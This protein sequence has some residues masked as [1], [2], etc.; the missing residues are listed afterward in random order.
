M[1]TVGATIDVLKAQYAAERKIIESGPSLREVGEKVRWVG[2]E[3]GAT[4]GAFR[5]MFTDIARWQKKVSTDGFVIQ[6]ESPLEELHFDTWADTLD[7]LTDNDNEHA[8][9]YYGVIQELA[10][11]EDDDEESDD[12]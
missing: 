5:W 8:K 9:R 12:D 7:Y 6:L 3:V 1:S 11:S 10:Y 2:D 4:G